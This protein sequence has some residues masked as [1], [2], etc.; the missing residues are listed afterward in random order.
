MSKN[1]FLIHH[2]LPFFFSVIVNS[3][4]TQI[5]ILI[6]ITSTDKTTDVFLHND[7]LTIP[8]QCAL[9]VSNAQLGTLEGTIC[10]PGYQP[11]TTTPI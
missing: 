1:I 9:M 7:E 2:L 8:S 3:L 6:C 5:K 4:L 11:T 10:E